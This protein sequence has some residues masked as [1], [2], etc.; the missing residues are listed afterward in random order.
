MVMMITFRL[1]AGALRPMAF[2]FG[3][4]ASGSDGGE[5]VSVM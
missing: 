2:G 4:F 3:S 1:V 5:Y